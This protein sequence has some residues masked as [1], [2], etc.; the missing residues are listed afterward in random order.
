M[1]DL[2]SRCPVCKGIDT[3]P[4]PTNPRAMFCPTCE[5]IFA[6][7]E[8]AV[9]PDGYA[10]AVRAVNRALFD[11]NLIWID[12]GDSP[13]AKAW[14]GPREAMGLAAEVATDAVFRVLQQR[15]QAAPS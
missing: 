15:A 14:G 2:F 4:D 12:T 13:I 6:V 3:Q 7:D 11:E 5:T 9:K 1:S 10:D 8:S